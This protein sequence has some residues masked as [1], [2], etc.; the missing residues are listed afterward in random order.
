MTSP[1]APPAPREPSALAR[2]SRYLAKRDWRDYVVYLGLIALLIIFSI[3]LADAGFTSATN[4]LNVIRQSAIV[5]V[6]AVSMTFAIAAGQIDLSVGSIAGL[7]AVVS[8]LTVSPLG[9]LPAAL[10]GILVGTIVGATNGLFVS[11]LGVPSFLV[12]LGMLGIAKG[13]AMVVS[14]TAPIPILDT[15]FTTVFG[16]GVLLGLPVLLYWLLLAG[17]LGQITLKH[18]PFG[19]RLL[20]TGGNEEAAR[21]SG[22]RTRRT[23]FAVM[24]LS[25]AVAGFV[26]LL[27]AGR[28][29]TG[30]FESG[31]GDELTAI[32][33][34]VLGGAA[35]SGGKGSVP[36]AIVGAVL[37]GVVNNGLTLMGLDYATRVIV[38]GAI[39]VLAVALRR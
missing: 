1:T 34:A 36:G 15:T 4:L 27:Y 2:A 37:L 33:A 13:L 11:W 32:A 24:T 21:F 25:G 39:I 28:L 20:A 5:S 19:R 30:R 9:V 22:V 8:A 31:T 26:G 18:T 17:L 14:G 29:E 23:T 7:S 10:A 3:T 35:F 38:Q 12:T 6:L 16:G